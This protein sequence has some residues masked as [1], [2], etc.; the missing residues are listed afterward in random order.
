M[1]FVLQCLDT[2]LSSA[3]QSPLCERRMAVYNELMQ[4]LGLRYEAMEVVSAAVKKLLDFADTELPMLPTSPESNDRQPVPCGITEGIPSFKSWGQV[5]L[6]HPKFYLR[7]S[8]SLDY[9][10]SRGSYPSDHELPG[11]VLG[12][13]LQEPLCTWSPANSLTLLRPSS[14]FTQIMSPGRNEDQCNEQNTNRK[15]LPCLFTRV[16]L[17]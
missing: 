3:S 14:P 11:W 4:S 17:L 13:Y 12:P 16:Q 1:P 7:L 5:I 10:V 2:K 6:Q 9:C 15:L 8:L